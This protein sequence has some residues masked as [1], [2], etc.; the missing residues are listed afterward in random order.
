MAPQNANDVFSLRDEKNYLISID[1]DRILDILETNSLN[2]SLKNY[3]IE[4]V[5]EIESL[6][7]LGT[8]ADTKKVLVGK[9]ESVKAEELRLNPPPGIIIAENEMLHYG[10]K[11]DFSTIQLVSTEE[12]VVQKFRFRVLGKEDKP[13]AD[14]QVILKTIN[15]D[16]FESSTD[17]NGETE[18]EVNNIKKFLDIKVTYL[19]NYWDFYLKTPM[20]ST[21][22]IIQIRMQSLNETIKGFPNEFYFGWGQSLIG[23]DKLPKE[24]RTGAGVKIA[25]IDSGC[26]NS[27]P[28]LSHIT[29]GKDFTGD[30]DPNSWNKDK[31][32]HGTHCAGIIAARGNSNNPFNGFAP[33][34]EIHILRV[35]P[36]GDY[37]DVA[38][39]LKYCRENQI[40]IVNM[41][42]GGTPAINFVLEEQI[43]LAV[44]S[45]IACI[46]ASGN[47]ASAVMYPAS[48]PNT[49][50]VAAVGDY[51]QL[52]P[53]TWELTTKQDGFI[54]SDGIFLADFN[55]LG[56][57]VDVFAPGVGVISTFLGGGYKPKSGTSMAAPH[58]SGLAA[59]LLAHH[60]LFQNEYKE[61]NRERVQAL[62]KLL[63]S[64]TSNHLFQS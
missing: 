10:E 18:I 35:F 56:P 2:E 29:L 17:E 58:I 64:H 19:N 33:N 39:A 55:C 31:V 13:L 7:P 34:A 8:E 61:R 50:A 26:D 1:Q 9:I 40:D 51:K 25:I 54:A 24:K 11:K 48:S 57:E 32:G 23:L 14:A 42:L 38:D 4:V 36:N 22:Q 16:K 44:N 63:R 49:L 37:G 43:E 12:Q 41:S 21:E 27:H 47:S 3:G 28:S 46:A 59:L 53:K 5:R 45:G 52:Q 15:G 20:I 6:T 30:S 60:S 62:Y